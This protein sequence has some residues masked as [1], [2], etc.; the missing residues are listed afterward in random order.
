MRPKDLRD[1]QLTSVFASF[2]GNFV[3]MGFD[4]GLVAKHNLQSGQER[5]RLKLDSA[6]KGL[7]VENEGDILWAA[8]KD[9]VLAVSTS[10]QESKSF[11]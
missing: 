10:K 11:I 1:R 2:C 4:N 5:L 3:F 9:G 7:F 6:V 8:L